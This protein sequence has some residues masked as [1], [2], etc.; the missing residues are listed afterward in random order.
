MLGAVVAIW[1][2][3]NAVNKEVDSSINLAVQLIKMGGVH[4]G[5]NTADSTHWLSS[6][7]TLNETRHLTIQLIT[8]TGKTVSLIR[9]NSKVTL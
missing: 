3:R 9:K 1:Q 4:N 2:A 8:P 6:L 5:A 7:N